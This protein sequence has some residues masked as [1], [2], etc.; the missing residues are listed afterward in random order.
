MLR[1][2]IFLET[3]LFM[4]VVV[5]YHITVHVDTIGAIL[6]LEKKYVYKWKM[7]IDE[8]HHFI[9]GYV[10]YVTVKI[11]MLVNKKTPHIHLQRT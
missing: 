8:P 11:K 6:L 4:G 7:H 10:E 5:E 2:N 9:Q 3:L 1:N